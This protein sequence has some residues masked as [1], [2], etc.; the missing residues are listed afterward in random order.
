M[1]LTLVRLVGDAEGTLGTLHH[2]NRIVCLMGEL[3]WRDNR[4]NISCIPP[5]RY[6]VTY[7]A[8]SGSGRYRDVYHV[9]DVRGRSGILIHAGNYSGDRAQG[10][11][12]DS[13]G[14]LLPG[15]RP[16]RLSGQR[17]VL[18]SRGALAALHAVTGRKGF[19]LEVIGV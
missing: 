16:G 1:K 6:R 19:E 14:C 4:S 15:L 3:P 10:L 2:G 8:R 11:R 12:T 17:A 5:G 13:H 9:R 7:L 18:A